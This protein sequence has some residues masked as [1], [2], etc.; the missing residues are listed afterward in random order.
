M[1]KRL[2]TP[3]KKWLRR[4]VKQLDEEL[5]AAEARKL[6]NTYLISHSAGGIKVFETKNPDAF[7]VKLM[8]GLVLIAFAAAIVIEVVALTS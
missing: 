1:A 3:K 5:A 7:L 6:K 8:V 2:R 4:W